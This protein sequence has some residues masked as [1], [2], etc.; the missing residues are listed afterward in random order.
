MSVILSAMFPLSKSGG[1]IAYQ[2][3]Q[4]HNLRNRRQ[5]G[6]IISQTNM[7]ALLSVQTTAFSQIMYE[8]DD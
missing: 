2:H 8:I 3:T 1:N 7:R 5:L 4:L 6:L